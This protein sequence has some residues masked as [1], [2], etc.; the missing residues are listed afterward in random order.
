MGMVCLFHTVSDDTLDRI[1]A[2]PPLI[3]RLLEPEDDELYLETIGAQKKKGLFGFSKKSKLKVP[4]LNLNAEEQLEIDLDKSWDGIHFCLTGADYDKE[5]PLGFIRTGGRQVG[6]IDIGHGPARAF[7]SKDIKSLWDLIDSIDLRQLEE[8][9]D[10]D[11]MQQ[12]GIYPEIWSED[13]EAGFQYISEH[14]AQLKELLHQCTK[15]ELG[16]VVFFC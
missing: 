8:N 4:D 16:L 1:L 2:D 5:T 11:K 3:L 15:D 12:L 13:H 10:P 14:Y 9:Y 7:H 6:N